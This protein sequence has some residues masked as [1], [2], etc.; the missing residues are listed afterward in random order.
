MTQTKTNKQKTVRHK[1]ISYR[2]QHPII[3]FTL[4]MSLNYWN[5]KEYIL[6]NQ[7]TKCLLLNYE[8]RGNRN[9][10]QYL[11]LFFFKKYFRQYSDNI[12]RNIFKMDHKKSL[13]ELQMLIPDI[14]KVKT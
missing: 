2:D 14:R 4:I 5:A 3:A 11:A 10:R 12:I 8:T 9:I 13:E 7:R 6:H 1:L